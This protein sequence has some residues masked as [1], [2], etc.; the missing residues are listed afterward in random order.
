MHT[1]T[2][3]TKHLQQSFAK[4][5]PLLPPNPLKPRWTGPLKGWWQWQHFYKTPRREK[6]RLFQFNHDSHRKLHGQKTMELTPFASMSGTIVLGAICS[7]L[8]FTSCSSDED[9]VKSYSNYQITVDDASP[10]SLTDFW[11]TRTS[12]SKEIC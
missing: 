7:C 9:P 1:R 8:L 2:I 12:V 3:H 6:L 11:E 4:L 5:L 10:V